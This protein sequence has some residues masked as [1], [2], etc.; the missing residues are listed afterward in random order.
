MRAFVL[1]P[2]ILF[3][4]LGA[5]VSWI[6]LKQE[7]L[8]QEIST[9]H[10]HT[11]WLSLYMVSFKEALKDEI[12]SKNLESQGFQTFSMTIDNHFHYTAIIKK[13]DSSLTKNNLYFVDIFGIYQ[14]DFQTFSLQKDFILVLD[15]F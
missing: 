3:V 8:T 15:D 5:M 1:L 10:T 7:S 12:A 6:S 4:I 11:K 13:F 9:Q 14:D 2:L